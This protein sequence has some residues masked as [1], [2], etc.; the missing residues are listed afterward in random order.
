MG[1]WQDGSKGRLPT[2]HGG[3]DILGGHVSSLGGG[4]RGG[5]LPYEAADLMF[6]LFPK[7]K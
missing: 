4:G 1:G 2:N 3:E 5:L 7:A 6:I